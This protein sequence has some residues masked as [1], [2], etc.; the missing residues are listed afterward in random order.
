MEQNLPPSGEERQFQ[1]VSGASVDGAPIA[2][3]IVLA[4]VVTALS[5]IPFSVVLAVGG[6][7]PLSQSILPLLGW[8]LGPIAG[9]LASGIGTLI[10]VFFAPYT[11]GIPALTVGIAMLISF[12]AGTMVARN[13]RRYWYLGLTIL[14]ILQFCLYGYQAIVRNGITLNNFILGSFVDWSGLL[15]FALPTRQ[16]FARWIGSTN[17]GLVAIGLF[18][19]TWTISGVGHLSAASIAYLILNW[20][21]EIWITL[22]PIIPVENV[23]RS[24]AGTVIGTGVISGLRAINLVKP[25]QALY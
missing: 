25:K 22:I 16:L 1:T 11:A 7:M 18:M 13:G 8:L 4:A 9:A 20:P 6:G 23:I 12:A 14:F 3:L 15:L 5:F 24:V 21:Q 2:Y 19:G 10:G 17:V